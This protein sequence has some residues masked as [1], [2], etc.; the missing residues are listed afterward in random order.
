MLLLNGG[1][2]LQFGWVQDILI[3]SNMSERLDIGVWLARAIVYPIR[4]TN[5]IS[6]RAP[7]FHKRSTTQPAHCSTFMSHKNGFDFTNQQAC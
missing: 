1:L 7:K 5:R 4:T 3:T 6:F 2:G